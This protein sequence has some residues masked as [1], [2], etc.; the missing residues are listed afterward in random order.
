MNVRS[1][2]NFLEPADPDSSLHAAWVRHVSETADTSLHEQVP[3][4]YGD[5]RSVGVAA[6]SWNDPGRL[7]ERD[8]FQQRNSVLRRRAGAVT[9]VLIASA[10]AAV[11]IVS[12]YILRSSREPRGHTT[13]I[14]G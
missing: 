8:N 4:Q 5:Q 12:L 11:G 7:D 9:M 10:L 13:E 2:E 1:S 3:E 14:G 6:S